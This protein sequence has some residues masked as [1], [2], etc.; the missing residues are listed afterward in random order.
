MPLWIEGFIFTSLTLTFGSILTLKA[1]NH[2][3]GLLRAKIEERKGDFATYQKIK[4]KIQ[5]A[6]EEQKKKE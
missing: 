4:K 2:L 3:A 6:K 1:R 5:Q